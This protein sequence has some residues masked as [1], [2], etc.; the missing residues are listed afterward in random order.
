MPD[1]SVRN[2]RN[3]N[4]NFLSKEHQERPS[5]SIISTDAMANL[6]NLPIDV[7][8]VLLRTVLYEDTRSFFAL[9]LTARDYYTIYHDNRK[10]FRLMLKRDTIRKFRALGVLATAMDK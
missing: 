7:K 5:Y 8:Y 3:I 6:A 10:Y 4:I 9:V 2:I 1:L